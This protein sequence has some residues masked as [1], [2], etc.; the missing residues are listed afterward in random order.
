MIELAALIIVVSI[1]VLFGGLGI[2][3]TV[4]SLFLWQ[5]VYRIKNGQWMQGID[6]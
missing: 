3:I 6:H 1:F 2:A 5:I 4:A